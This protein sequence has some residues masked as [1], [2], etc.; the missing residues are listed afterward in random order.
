MKNC[1]NPL[2]FA[3]YVFCT[4]LISS[5]VLFLKT[6]LVFQSEEPR[7]EIFYSP[8]KLSDDYT[9]QMLRNDFHHCITQPSKTTFCV[10]S[11]DTKAFLGSKSPSGPDDGDQDSSKSYNKGNE[12]QRKKLHPLHASFVDFSRLSKELNIQP[13]LIEPSVLFCILNQ[14]SQNLL[15]RR[16]FNLSS[17]IGDENVLTFAINESDSSK[18]LDAIHR[19]EFLH[20][21]FSHWSI[22]MDRIEEG[23][24]NMTT[25]DRRNHI[26]THHF[27]IRKRTV[28]HA[29]VFYQRQNYLWHGGINILPNEVLNFTPME[30]LLFSKNEAIYE[31]FVAVEVPAEP[32]LEALYIPS[33]P[34]LLLR[35]ME[36]SHFL[37]CNSSNGAYVN[38]TKKSH[39][40]YMSQ[41]KFTRIAAVALQEMKVQ[42][43]P[44][45]M[46]FWI[47][48]GT[49]LGWY[50]QC[51]I[52]PYTTDVDFAAWATDL[53]DDKKLLKKFINNKHLKMREI[54][55]L[56][57]EALE[58]RLTS[59][60]LLV[61]LFFCYD[62]GEHYWVSGHRPSKGYY[63]PYYYPRF[64]LCSADLLGHK[65]QVPCD[66]LKVIF[67]DYGAEWVKPISTWDYESSPKNKGKN[68]YWYEEELPFIY[69][70]Y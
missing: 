11:H 12:A 3:K 28:I 34:R 20:S 19:E 27:L 68:H 1:R 43:H 57:K 49:L 10:E 63:F 17:W 22:E 45:L 48:G 2:R 35:Q 39:R 13:M 26:E 4:L 51:G 38:E 55:G 54:M 36:S 50:R 40:E 58:Y 5:A 69:V 7:D 62:D 23:H 21:G 31:R 29:V 14:D 33:D 61:D 66:T 70:K 67:A 16:R 53:D 37:H 65:V 24:H 15:I 6:A 60:G 56:P 18:L 59:H 42:L 46:T 9:R 64:T 8:E 52:I 25:S 44:E 47:M 30:K 32:V 41:E